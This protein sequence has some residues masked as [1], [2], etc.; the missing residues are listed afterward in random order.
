MRLLNY[1]SC[2]ALLLCVNCVSLKTA[3]K[4]IDEIPYTRDKFGNIWLN[5]ADINKDPSTILPT[6]EQYLATKV[7]LEG[8]FIQL[9]YNQASYIPY[10]KSQGFK[11]YR[12]NEE[13]TVWIFRNGRGIPDQSNTLGDARVALF[14]DKGEMLLVRDRGA[15]VWTLPGG[16]VEAKELFRSGA[17]REVKEETGKDIDEAGLQLVAVANQIFSISN[18]PTNIVQY[19]F[20]Y[21]KPLDNLITIEQSEIDDYIWINLDTIKENHSPKGFSITKKVVTLL[22]QFRSQ[23]SKSFSIFDKEIP[24]VID[25][26]KW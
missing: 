16:G 12:L 7:D 1:F 15:K 8:C 25:A 2:L 18:Q 4:N 6:I 20:V 17:I 22:P 11:P 5:L 26:F 13:E 10:L 19:F 14:N 21:K 24:L 3:P 9:P 23:S